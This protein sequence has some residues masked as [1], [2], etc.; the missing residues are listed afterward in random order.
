MECCICKKEIEEYF[1]SRNAQPIKNGRCCIECDETIVLPTRLRI[2][3]PYLK[4]EEEK[5]EW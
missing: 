4:A 2:L 5:Y 1:D 3:E